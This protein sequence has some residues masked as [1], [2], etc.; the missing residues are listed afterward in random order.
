MYLNFKKCPKCN[1]T[2]VKVIR[3]ELYSDT[4]GVCNDCK[5]VYQLED[6]A[7]TSS[8]ICEV[9]EEEEDIINRNN[10]ES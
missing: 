2:N 6:L 9:V 4:I 8:D 10:T 1:S 7:N 5:E 3:G